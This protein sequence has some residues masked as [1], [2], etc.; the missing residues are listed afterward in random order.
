M[1]RLT[2]WI[3]SFGVDATE[4][5]SLDAPPAA[6][7][8]GLTILSRGEAVGRYV[9][10]DVLG[11]GGMGVVYSAYDPKL[12]RRIALK[13]LRPHGG[14]SRQA[15]GRARLLREA[16]ALAQLNHPNVVTVHDVGQHEDQVFVAMEFVDGLTLKAWVEQGPHP[17]KRVVG[18]MTAAGRGLSAAHAKKMVHRDF[19]PENVMLTGDGRRVLVMDFGLVTALELGDSGEL[20]PSLEELLPSNVGEVPLTMT[21]RALGTPAYMAPEQFR[22]RSG[23]AS[24]QFSFCV[25]LFE[26][27]YGKRPFRAS[28]IQ[29][30]LRAIMSQGIEEAPP[31]DHV[32]RWLRDVVVRGLASKPKNRWP[33][34]H[35]LLDALGHAPSRMRWYAVGALG[36]AVL[37]GGVYGVGELQEHR[38]R[39]ACDQRATAIDELWGPAQRE[40]LQAAFANSPLLYADD[41][42]HRTEPKLDAAARAW[43]SIRA[44]S[45]LAEPDT[46]AQLQEAREVCL[47]DR[48]RRFSNVVNVLTEADARTIQRASQLAEIEVDTCDDDAHLRGVRLSNDPQDREARL[49]IQQDLHYARSLLRLGRFTRAEALARAAI[50][51]TVERDDR[52]LLASASEL[53]GNVHLGQ[54][55]YAEAADALAEAYFA[56][57]ETG[58]R[59][60]AGAASRDLIGVHGDHLTDVNEARRWAQHARAAIEE[61]GRPLDRAAL[62]LALGR[63]ELVAGNLETGLEHGLRALRLYTEHVGPHAKV[64]VDARML[65]AAIY[66]RKGEPERA[67][68]L[69]RSV[70]E[71]RIEAVGDAHPQTNKARINLAAALLPSKQYEEAEPVL[72][73]AI[74]LLQPPNLD[75]ADAMNNLSL[76]LLLTGNFEEADALNERVIELRRTLLP[77]GSTRVAEA[78]L[79]ATQIQ[80][81][82]GR[83]DDA[84]R[85]VWEARAI[86]VAKL[87]EEHP[88]VLNTYKVEGFLELSKGEPQKAVEAFERGRAILLRLDPR[89]PI[90]QTLLNAQ[91]M[92]LLEAGDA[93]QALQLVSLVLDDPMPVGDTTTQGTR[94]LALLELGR[95]KEAHAVMAA[96]LDTPQFKAQGSADRAIA[97]ALY[98]RTRWELARPKNRDAIRADVESILGSLDRKNAELGFVLLHLDAWLERKA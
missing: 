22:G 36:V 86:F 57:T 20:D 2:E 55:R 37:A 19:K 30:L 54:T 32:P 75:T 28:S 35:A 77:E 82:L 50:A 60:V 33:S 62:D 51:Q 53:L 4:P 9:V 49:S 25:T 34:M 67:L 68:S 44:A 1:N 42:W 97:S 58:N 90:M 80:S 11:F 87:G 31:R 23:P 6:R 95:A 91:A 72:R 38:R 14:P 17:W 98:Q 3:V 73:R 13:L 56:A 59:D 24:D 16:Q 7:Q 46:P 63:L 64:T 79:N 40:R 96:L 92:S 27:L 88:H 66:D 83:F 85:S 41:A 78:L 84:L 39:V 45:C 89:S 74:E 48:L 69:S 70:L 10:V 94:V 8:R 5:G 47:Q 29:G 76:A 61:S 43:V 52:Y 71:S 12:D 15:R 65:L 93:A 26:A 21:G 18:V 81:E